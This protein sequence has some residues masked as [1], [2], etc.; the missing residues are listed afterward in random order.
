MDVKSTFLH[1]DLQEEIYMEPPPDDVHN[2]SSLVCC[3]KKSL[4]GLKQAP[5][6]WYAKM[7]KFLLDA[8]FSRCHYDPNVYTKKVG[9]HL[10]ILVLSVDDLTLTG[11]DPKLLTHVKSI[12]K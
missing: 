10:V 1:G 7:D 3:L 2:D 9:S 6:A 5:Q 11:S 8:I 4:Y 12:L